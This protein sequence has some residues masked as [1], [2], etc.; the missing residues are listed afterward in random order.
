MN[1]DVSREKMKEIKGKLNSRRSVDVYNACIDIRK[2]VIK[3]TRGIDRLVRDQ[4][5]PVLLGILK[6]TSAEQVLL[7]RVVRKVKS[8]QIPRTEAIRTQIQSSKQKR[9]KNNLQIV[10][11]QREHMVNR[12]S[13]LSK[14]MATQQTKPN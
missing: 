2:N 1:R 5:I 12:V 13:S 11:I 4:V 9:G 6:K 14:K 10:K 8:M 3:T 7:R